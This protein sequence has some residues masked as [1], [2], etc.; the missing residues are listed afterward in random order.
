M[1]LLVA[2]H[3]TALTILQ[4]LCCRHFALMHTTMRP[5]S[6]RQASFSS[7]LIQA[8]M[9]LHARAARNMLLALTQ[10]R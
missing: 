2:L 1:S 9:M 3:G 10:P 5:C 8:L 4:L 7:V 6:V